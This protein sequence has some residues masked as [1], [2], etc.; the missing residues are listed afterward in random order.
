M[1]RSPSKDTAYTPGH[2]AKLQEL[3]KLG[4]PII[5][6]DSWLGKEPK[7]DASLEMGSKVVRRKQ[8]FLDRP[9][10]LINQMH[11][12]EVSGLLSLIEDLRNEISSTR[13]ELKK[14]DKEI[15]ELRAGR[16]VNS[17]FKGL[18]NAKKTTACQTIEAKPKLEV[19]NLSDSSV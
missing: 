18:L 4:E 15:Y 14:R 19:I 16:A 7:R 17:S 10:A 8:P 6:N 13:R 3:Q 5:S 12:E 2:L 1:Y 11:E 9:P